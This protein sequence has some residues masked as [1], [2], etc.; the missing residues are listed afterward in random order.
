MCLEV[1]ELD[2]GTT[3]RTVIARRRAVHSGTALK[4][5]G[6]ILRIVEADKRSAI[7][8]RRSPR[9]DVSKKIVHAAIG[10]KILGGRPSRLLEVDVLS[11]CDGDSIPGGVPLRPPG[12][13]G[14]VHPTRSVQLF[15]SNVTA[16]AMTAA[17]AC[18]SSTKPLSA[19]LAL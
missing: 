17:A 16:S 6:G 4:N 15:E 9:F 2:P 14:E 3:R 13:V 7:V 11:P 12:F 8:Q 1:I 18:R 19:A 5:A 10:P